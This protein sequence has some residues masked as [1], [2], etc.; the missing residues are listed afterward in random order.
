[1]ELSN[2]PHRY[3]VGIQ[4]YPIILVF[5]SLFNYVYYTS[6]M[7]IQFG[8]VVTVRISVITSYWELRFVAVLRM[9]SNST[10]PHLTNDICSSAGPAT[11]QL[12]G[13]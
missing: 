13:F 11:Y 1:M 7:A 10:T 3:I 9:K 4:Q 8:E 5:S 2:G 12:N 6:N